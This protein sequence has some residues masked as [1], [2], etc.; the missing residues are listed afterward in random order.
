[1]KK[2]TTHIL[3]TLLLLMVW[4]GEV[5]AG[6]ITLYKKVAAN[7]FLIKNV[8]A[9]TPLFANCTKAI[10]NKNSDLNCKFLN[11]DDCSFGIMNF[12]NAKRNVTIERNAIKGVYMG[13]QIN[14][15]D[16]DS[17]YVY[18]NDIETKANGFTYTYGN[19]DQPM[20]GRFGTVGIDVKHFLKPATGSHLIL[21][22]E[23]T[24]PSEA[25]RG[26]ANLKASKTHNI[27]YNTVNFTLNY[28]SNAT[29]LN[30]YSDPSLYGMFTSNS[31]SVLFYNNHVN[32]I[33]DSLLWLGTYGKGM[34]FETSPQA[35]IEC[36]TIMHTK[37]GLYAWG[38]NSTEDSKIKNNTINFTRN[39]L[40]TLD[41]GNAN[42]G[43]FGDI[44]TANEDNNNKWGKKW[45]QNNI[46]KIWR[47]SDTTI[48]DWIYTEPILL[49][50]TESGS[51]LLNVYKYNVDNPQSQT[52]VNPCPYNPITPFKDDEEPSSIDW[53]L[54]SIELSN[55]LDNGG[56]NV[57][58][59]EQV[60]EWMTQKHVFELLANHP[61]LLNSN[62]LNNFYS[63]FANTPIG[64]L[65]N[66]DVAIA[67]LTDFEGSEAELINKYNVAMTTNN[68]I[69]PR[70]DYEVNEQAVNNIAIK[71]ARFGS[72][73]LDE[74]DKLELEVLANMC[75]FVG[76]DAV[77]KA[78]SLYSVLNP[79]VQYN[80]RLVCL[81]VTANKGGTNSS[82]SNIDSLYEEQVNA[83][84]N[85]LAKQQTSIE[86]LVSIYPNPAS[87]F[88]DIRSDEEFDGEFIL[89]NTL[90]EIIL[91]EKIVLGKNIQRIKIN[92]VSNG[93]YQ[94]EIKTASKQKAV[95]KLSIIN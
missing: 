26:I 35:E 14:N 69:V 82:T 29:P 12:N 42:V 72:S 5:M 89:L 71:M 20:I 34:Y 7:Y 9:T 56:N 16:D 70:N 91:A 4:Q 37:Q 55:L 78:R 50:Q 3:M 19:P 2:L 95:G 1:M 8:T 41:R 80:D 52:K 88:I 21:D 46:Y 62:V 36:N 94:Y 79:M 63:N 93:V 48:N 30:N 57:I 54:L 22:N 6:N 73:I 31:D 85:I 87:N 83:T 15:L 43:T 92:N 90:G 59:Y 24:I 61:A 28:L 53:Q 74:T 67:S 45:I 47:N 64:T 81:G 10:I 60:A 86:N 23:I 18:L 76:G 17:F 13:I 68:A 51:N 75:P 27:N 77:Y 65:Y 66:A 39:P 32:G 84:A 44:G 58:S 33:T 25:G 40:Y 38:D 49:I 11:I